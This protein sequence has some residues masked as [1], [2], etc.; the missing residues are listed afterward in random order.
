MMDEVEMSRSLATASTPFSLLN[1]TARFL[2][3]AVYLGLRFFCIFFSR[4]LKS[5]G[6][7][8]PRSPLQIS[9]QLALFR[10]K[11]DFFLDS[12]KVLKAPCPLSRSN[13]PAAWAPRAIET[14]PK[15]NSLVTSNRSISSKPEL[16]HRRADRFALVF[17]SPYKEVRS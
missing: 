9:S 14:S 8:A 13:P 6:M 3:S 4:C 17:P 12:S 16:R 7:Y 2:N 10:E 1:S 11:I 15:R 5:I